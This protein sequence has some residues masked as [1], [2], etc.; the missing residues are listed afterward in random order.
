MNSRMKTMYPYWTS[1]ERLFQILSNRI[2]HCIHII[3]TSCSQLR[4]GSVI[5]CLLVEVVYWPCCLKFVYPRINLTFMGLIL[6]SKLPV[7][8][9]LDNFEWFYFEISSEAKYFFLSCLRYCDWGLIVV[10]V[11]YFQIWSKKE[12]HIIISR[13]INSHFG[14]MYIETPYTMVQWKRQVIS[15]GWINLEELI[16][17]R[18]PLNMDIGIRKSSNLV[19]WKKQIIFPS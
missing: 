19:E 13:V 7:K 3:R 1:L 15:P 17:M 2:S 9:W 6:K 18:Y 10:I 14:S 12:H 5:F 16:D 8:F 11:Y 4:A